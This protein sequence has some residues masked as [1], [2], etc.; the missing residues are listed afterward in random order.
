MK[1]IMILLLSVV[2]ITGCTSKEKSIFENYKISDNAK[3]NENIK[4]SILLTYD[5]YENK[6]KNKDSF[7]LLLWQTGCG[8]CQTFEP[9]LN[10]VIDY[11]NL[12]IYSINVATLTDDQY[13]KL[14]NKT[15]VSGT[16]TTVVFKDGITQSKKLVGSKDEQTVIDFLVRYGYLE[17]VK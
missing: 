9:I 7:V 12:E 17:E 6:I 5:E 3:V 4:E 15:F 11:Y 16:P 8:H 10:S 1:K 2:L 13:S 14:K